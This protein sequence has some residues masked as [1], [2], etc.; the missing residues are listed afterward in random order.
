[1]Q[2]SDRR[3]PADSGCFVFYF[4]IVRYSLLS[5]TGAGYGAARRLGLEEYRRTLFAPERMRRRARLFQSVMLH[6]LA[7]QSPALDSSRHRVMIYTSL[8]L[9]AEDRALLD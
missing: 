3:G 8:S 1:M 2:S 7:R 5:E 6:S 4:T 9:P